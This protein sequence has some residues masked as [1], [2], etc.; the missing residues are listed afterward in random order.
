MLSAAQGR[1]GVDLA[2]AHRPDLVLL[3]LHLPDM[4]GL[5]VLRELRAAEDTSGIP[6]VV[7]SA[8]ATSRHAQE[9]LTA[10]AQFYMTKP[11]DVPS[12]LRL[13][14]ET[15]RSTQGEPAVPDLETLR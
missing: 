1:L 9:L 8:D 6:V 3:D 11:L 13:L 7:V 5:E 12:M 4:P 14:D 15:L 10:G 2:R